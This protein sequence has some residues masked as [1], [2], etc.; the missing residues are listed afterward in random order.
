MGLKKGDFISVLSETSSQYLEIYFACAK[1]GIVTVGLN[2]RLSSQEIAS[3]INNAEPVLLFVGDGFIESAESLRPELKTIKKYVSL[4]KPTDNMVY[5]EDIISQNTS[6]EPDVEVNEDDLFTIIFTGGTTGLPK[7]VMISHRNML[8]EVLA[9]YIEYGIK[10]SDRMLF[11]LPMFHTT[12]FGPLLHLF[13]GAS[14]VMIKRPDPLLML[15]LIEKEKITFINAV[16]TVY[17]LLILHPDFKKYDLSSL[18]LL[19]Y[20]GSAM[21]EEVFKAGVKAFGNIFCQIYG[22]TEGSP[23]LIYKQELKEGQPTRQS[24]GRE[25][26]M[27]D[28]KVVGEDGKE[29]KPGET[30]EIMYKGKNVM[31]GYFKNPEL[32][33][34]TIE[35]GWIHTNDIATIDEE[36]YIYMMD[37]K[38]DMIK[39]GGENVYPKEVEDVIY[40]H[41]SVLE[42]AVVGVPDDKW[43][44]AVKAVIVLK[45]GEQVSEK[46]IIEHCKKKIGGYKC[47][48]SV[49]FVDKLPKTG[50]EKISRTEVK[51]RYWKEGRRIG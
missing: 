10:S 42:V 43:V 44:E 51:K 48:R 17:N 22:M 23:A 31:V 6:E 20:G 25:I 18:R 26:I 50:L 29:I 28:A 5:Y 32:T 30:G 45:P 27:V 41:P 21:P 33:A 47:P 36:G 1:L 39:T 16:A 49:D 13:A 37:R 11:L 4:N 2:F 8:T 7:G 19:S 3:L 34:K 35:K 38:N 9:F 24:L 46:E 12:I 40:E 15:Q 14:V